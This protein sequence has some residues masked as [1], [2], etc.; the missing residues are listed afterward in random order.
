[1]SPDIFQKTV[2]SASFTRPI[3]VDFWADWCDPCKI[4]EPILDELKNENNNKWVLVKIDTDVS[5]EIAS[6]YDIMGVP[7]IRIFWKG[8]IIGKYNGLMWKKDM[9]RWIEEAINASMIDN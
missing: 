5:K 3:V 4:L 1:M 7:A 6:A 9:G 2:I 8:E